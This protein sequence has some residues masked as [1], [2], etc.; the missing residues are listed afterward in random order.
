MTLRRL[1]SG[2]VVAVVAASGWAHDTV[3]EQILRIT[4]LLRG[5]PRNAELY[6]RRA[7]LQRA[8]R[9]WR[10]ALADYQA[11]LSIKPN[12][13]AALL[14]RGFALLGDGDAV[15]AKQSFNRFLE[16]VPGNPDALLGRARCD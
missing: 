11:A 16:R 5:S 12:Y 4:L 8:A 15:A 14:G 13:P 3:D 10:P 2:M 6:F 7:E 1:G 9:Q